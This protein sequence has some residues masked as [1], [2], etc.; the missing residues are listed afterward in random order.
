MTLHLI[1]ALDLLLWLLTAVST[2]YVVFFAIVSLCS[3][4][5]RHL[6]DEPVNATSR[7]AVIYPAYNEDGV[8]RHSITTFLQQNYPA[9]H[10]L[11]AVVSDHMQPETNLWL[12]QQPIMLLQP[13]FEKSSK[14]KALQYAIEHFEQDRQGQPPFDRIVIL[15]ADNVV[16]PDFLSQLNALCHKGHQAIQCHRTAKNSDNDI[17]A[18]DGASEEINNTL[19]RRAHNA[20]GL[21][22][23]LIGSGMCFEYKW[24]RDHVGQLS[25]AGED[26]ELEA[27]LLRERIHVHYADDIRVLDEKVSS[28][29]NFQR[30]RL[31]WM[32]AQIQCLL[33]MMPYLPKA[34]ATGN[35]DY[36]DKVV[37]QALI[38]RSMLLV[39]T[40]GMAVIISV[41]SLLSTLFSPLA[42]L[43]WWALLLALCVS[44][45]AAIPRQ[46]RTASLFRKTM[47]V[48]QLVW[49]MLRNIVHI[50]TKSKD[51][52]HTTHDK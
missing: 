34:M 35:V 51:F 32:T 9:D 41:L 24:F 17:A 39:L 20:I 21:S 1:Q 47:L 10:F 23:A 7:F 52:I 5:K 42:A 2:A 13:V 43:K 44:L 3:R 11:L 19:F 46:L 18:L 27:M 40:T 4:R 22:S 49:R 12:A 50:D 25:T 26:R 14:A 29:D 36:M 6:T 38:P 30:Q 31:R 37:Q 45:Y 8:I 33:S 28:G 48:P 15:D 16:A